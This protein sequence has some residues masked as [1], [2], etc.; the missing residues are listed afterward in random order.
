MLTSYR[1]SAGDT[2]N[3]VAGA[4]AALAFR[5]RGALTGSTGCNKFSGT[6]VANGSAL[7]MKTG[8]MTLIACPEAQ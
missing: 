6:Y 5:P 7:T 8:V 4:T 3:A 2:V 1:G